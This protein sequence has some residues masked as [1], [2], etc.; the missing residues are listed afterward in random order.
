MLF[1]K[2]KNRRFVKYLHGDAIN[3][4][5]GNRFEYICNDCGRYLWLD[6]PDDCVQCRHF[7][8]NNDG[9]GGCDLVSSGKAC[10]EK[11]LEC[12]EETLT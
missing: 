6:S 4:H 2:H 5:N 12:W 9:S 10:H 7:F 8:Y 3:V 11:W 1:C